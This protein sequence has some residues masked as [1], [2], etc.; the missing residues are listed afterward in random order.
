M[1]HDPRYE[2]KI[3]ARAVLNEAADYIEAHGWCQHALKF[4][5]RV[6]LLGALQQ[7]DCYPGT[8]PVTA[9]ALWRLSQVTGAISLSAWNDAKGRTREQVV[10][11]LRRAAHA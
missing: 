2:T 7:A 3:R 5:G 10:E 9:E 6:C 11:A 8:G 1:L 4:R